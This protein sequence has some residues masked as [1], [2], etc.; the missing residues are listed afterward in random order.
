MPFYGAA[1]GEY[2]VVR[3]GYGTAAVGH[4]VAM[5]P[6]SVA[7]DPHSV[8]PQV[9]S[10]AVKGGMT[11]QHAILKAPSLHRWEAQHIGIA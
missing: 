1:W 3:K 9:D 6:Y 7:M 5:D 8:A 4:T 11:S 2:R 10:I